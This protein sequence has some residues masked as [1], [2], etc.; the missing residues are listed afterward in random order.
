MAAPATAADYWMQGVDPVVQQDRHASDPTDSM[1]LFKPDAPWPTVAS[2]LKS[3]M[4]STQ[5]ALRGS[6]DQVKSI[7][8]GLG[9]RHIA[10]TADLGV[11]V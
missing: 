9:R 6:D 4:T 1:D 7:L 8:D 10:L 5:M 11:L 2:R 3:F